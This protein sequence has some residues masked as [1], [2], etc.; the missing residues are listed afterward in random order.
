MEP[1][2]PQLDLR[3]TGHLGIEETIVYGAATAEM[4]ERAFDEGANHVAALM[5]HSART[6]LE[7]VHDLDNQLTEEGRV[8]ARELGERLPADVTVRGYASPV[9]RCQDTAQIALDAHA[10][11]GGDAR[12]N[13]TIEAL[14]PFYALD[15]M[16]MWKGMSLASGL[17]E[18][19]EQWVAGEISPGAIIR[20]DHAASLILDVLEDRLNAPLAD[21]R[22]GQLE[23]CV[24]HDITLYMVRDRL[25]GQPTSTAPVEYLDALIVYREPGE[26]GGLMM[27]SHH[28]EPVRVR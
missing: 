24:S 3:L 9:Q 6:Y 16:R 19:V 17:T 28:G 21:R 14:G 4:I 11:R 1:L 2:V 23:L 22:A 8:Y 15:Q 18:Y 20:A 10:G 12:R 5:R 7:G 25:L 27:C 26:E 13:R